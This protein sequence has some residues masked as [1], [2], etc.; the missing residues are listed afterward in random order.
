MKENTKYDLSVLYVEDSKIVREFTRRF[1]ELIFSNVEVA[2]DGEEGLKKFQDNPS[3]DIVITD[4]VMPNLDGVQMVKEIKKIN[5]N[6][7]LIV[8]SAYY[9]YDKLL[10]CVEAGVSD[11]I[12]KPL[13]A[14]KLKK[15]V[16]EHLEIE[17][18]QKNRANFFQ[19]MDTKAQFESIKQTHAPLHCQNYYKGVP[20]KHEANIVQVMDDEIII[21]TDELQGW[22]AVHQKNIILDCDLLDK[23]IKADVAEHHEF[24][25]LRLNNL[26]QFAKNTC[27]RSVTRVEP[28]NE[29]KMFVF[30][31]NTCFAVV[32]K[33]LSTKAIAFEI[34]AEESE[35]S[36]DELISDKIM[37]SISF[38]LKTTEQNRALHTTEKINS[39]VSIMRFQKTQTGYFVV[40]SVNFN[41]H[42]KELFEQYILQRAKEILVEMKYLLC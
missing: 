14:I 33:D 6:V 25:S 4:I 12:E 27:L 13:N 17:L 5:P 3:F 16:D 26:V 11:F 31:A 24:K 1:F 19:K 8:I 18:H 41:E 2:Y 40:V 34:E 39:K 7:L 21:T 15:I 9:D 30:I 38:D 42:D 10:G 28:C 23:S 36:E 32:A 37:V 35:L 20:I 29:F 22:A